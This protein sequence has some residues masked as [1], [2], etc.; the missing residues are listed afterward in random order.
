MDARNVRVLRLNDMADHATIYIDET[1]RS[2]LAGIPWG[3]RIK[4]IGRREAT[5]VIQPLPPC[6]A[7]GQIARMSLE[8]RDQA[9]VEWGEEVL[10]D[11]I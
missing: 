1:A 10:L 8:L 6:D 5:A 2:Y 3:S 11:S 4:I 9:M 7:D